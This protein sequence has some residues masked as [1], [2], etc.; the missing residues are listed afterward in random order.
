MLTLSCLLLV[1]TLNIMNRFLLIFAVLAFSVL[2]C[3][4]GISLK[5]THSLLVKMAA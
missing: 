2:W 5:V 1:Y 4:V 3:N